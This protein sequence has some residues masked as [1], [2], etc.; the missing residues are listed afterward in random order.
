MDRSPKSPSAG[1][2]SPWLAYTP[3][4][5]SK[6][7]KLSGSWRESLLSPTEPIASIEHPNQATFRFRP[8]AEET[9]DRQRAALLF[10]AWKWELVQLIVSIGM[11]IAIAVTVAHF[12]GLEIPQWPLAINLTTI[13][14]LLSVAM[15]AL[16]VACCAEVLSQAKWS[17]FKQPR[18]LYELERFDRASRGVSGSARLL[19][20]GQ[21]S[22]IATIAA[23]VIILSL[24]TGPFIQQSIQSITC[25][26]VDSKMNASIPTVNYAYSNVLIVPGPLSPGVLPFDLQA[27]PVYAMANPTGNDSAILADCPSGNCDWPS[28]DGAASYA[29]VGMCSTCFDTTSQLGPPGQY[30][31]YSLPAPYTDIYVGGGDGSLLS[32]TSVWNPPLN[33]PEGSLGSAPTATRTLLNVT[34]LGFTDGKC[35]DST[36][37]GCLGNETLVG[38]ASDFMQKAKPF[39]VTCGL[40]FC[41]RGFRGRVQNGQLNESLVGTTPMTSDGNHATSNWTA[42]Q[43]PCLID[44]QV[45][46]AANFSI[47]PTNHSRMAVVAADG[48]TIIT[49]YECVYKV[50]ATLAL[51]LYSQ[52]M[53]NVFWG[54]CTGDPIHNSVEC[55]D[56]WHEP[57]FNGGQASLSTISY[58]FDAF[59]A[60]FS[61]KLR[62]TGGSLYVDVNGNPSPGGAPGV[63]RVSTVCSFYLRF[64][65]SPA[66]CF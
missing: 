19:V 53:R 28:S 57:F 31:N 21:S 59:A 10:H 8:A 16:L 56:F 15:R 17:W 40:Q 41:V 22:V 65:S 1:D 2:E 62:Q 44:G 54:G 46:T 47:V 6:E 3:T 29:S 23:L 26:V 37:A 58:Q 60:A 49:P 33:Y 35:D 39:A 20:T 30:M 61:N 24:S 63:V 36:T 4:S 66:P 7:S 55:D 52:L 64:S 45:Y 27:A 14:S 11:L 13:V 5:P 38:V 51:A 48:T 42:I 25:S 12:D 18:R 34:I 50:N 43:D 32:V 9:T